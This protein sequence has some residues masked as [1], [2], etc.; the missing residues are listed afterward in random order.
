MAG[1]LTVIPGDNSVVSAR[2]S[3]GTQDSGAAFWGVPGITSWAEGGGDTPTRDI[4]A[5]E[6]VSSQS[7]RARVQTVECEVSAYAPRHR[8]WRLIRAA[9]VAK[10]ALEFRLKTQRQVIMAAPPS[11]V[12]FAVSAQGVVTLAGDA[13][14]A[15]LN[16]LKGS[17]F[18]PGMVL[19]IKD[20]SVN[21]AFLS[22]EDIAAE[23]KASALTVSAPSGAIAAT[24][25]FR[26]TV[27]S[28]RRGPFAATV[29]A[30]D[31]GTTRAE[32]DLSA[33]LSLTPLALLPEYE[34][35]DADAAAFA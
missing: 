25:A 24:A 2:G 23:A 20:G 11:N 28:M 9:L 22:I 13:S 12:T 7:G 26:I 21:P 4:V 8:A 33:G 14:D 15:F 17:E 29:A 6:G 18:A 1:G 5:F 16:R 19:E 3:A 10:S 30:A 35:D 32:G 31:R 34:I 27:P